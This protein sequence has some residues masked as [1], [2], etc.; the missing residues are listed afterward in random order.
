M[1][2]EDELRDRLERELPERELDRELPERELALDLRLR[3]AVLPFAVVPL[4]LP[5]DFDGPVLLRLLELE[6]RVLVCCAIAR[7]SS[8]FALPLSSG[9]LPTPATRLFREQAGKPA[10]G[11]RSGRWN[12][13]LH[14]RSIGVRRSPIA[15]SEWPHV[16]R[17]PSSVGVVPILR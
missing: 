9:K 6:L 5:L 3:D 10:L 7:P 16:V 13:A 8:G 1:L 4:R 12:E 2:R 14:V 15:G 17:S 11:G